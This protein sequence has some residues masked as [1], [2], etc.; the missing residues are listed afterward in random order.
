[1][2]RQGIAFHEKKLGQLFSDD[3]AQQI[4]DMLLAECAG[5]GAELRLNTA[6]GDVATLPDG[7]FRVGTA[8]GPVE[9]ASLVIATGGLSIPKIGA[10]RFGYDVARQFGMKVT[11]LRPAL[12]PLTFQANFLDRCKA[13][14][15]LSMDAEVRHG[16]TAFREGLLF[17]HRG[18]SGSS[19]LQI[20]SFGTRARGWPSILPPALTSPA[21]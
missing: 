13:L 5:V 6:V 20:S 15:G 3:S 12:V 10:T 17:T 8:S 11:D 16:K 1:M 18:L 4:I 19:I 2:E 21:R 14:A 7:G 9:C